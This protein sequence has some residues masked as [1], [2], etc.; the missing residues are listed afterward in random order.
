MWLNGQALIFDH[1]L[2]MSFITLNEYQN[3]MHF[4]PTPKS[5]NPTLFSERCYSE[6]RVGF[7]DFRKQ[8]LIF[9]TCPY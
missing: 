5:D 3:V 6:F 9:R 4:N 2:Q 1:V 8:Y 7:S